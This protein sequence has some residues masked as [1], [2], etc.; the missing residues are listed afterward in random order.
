MDLGG[1]GPDIRRSLGLSSASL[2]LIAGGALI[3]F[4]GMLPPR[5]EL[6]AAASSSAG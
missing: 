4:T 1:L 2:G 3:A 6:R 5:E